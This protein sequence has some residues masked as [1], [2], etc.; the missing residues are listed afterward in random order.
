M[1]RSAVNMWIR[2]RLEVDSRFPQ[3]P[4]QYI[5]ELEKAIEK[6]HP[7]HRMEAVE[8]ARQYAVLYY[9]DRHRNTPVPPRITARIERLEH[10]AEKADT[11]DRASAFV[12]KYGP[13]EKALAT[14]MRAPV[15]E[16]THGQK[17]QPVAIQDVNRL[18]DFERA[19]ERGHHM[20]DRPSSPTI[21]KE[22]TKE[23]L[24]GHDIPWMMTTG[25]IHEMS[26]KH[27]DQAQKNYEQWPHKDK[28]TFVEYVNFTR[29]H[30]H[31]SPEDRQ[32]AKQQER[33]REVEL[34]R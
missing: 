16:K 30:W 34:S 24:R 25:P 22:P 28:R 5:R 12:A 29:E 18:N 27:L 3:T 2:D 10:R 13:P 15:Q 4:K 14:F 32:P 19:Y 33:S 21:T 17:I 31:K 11:F 20:F 9:Q 7:G 6:A 23:R 8:Y 1:A 26:Q